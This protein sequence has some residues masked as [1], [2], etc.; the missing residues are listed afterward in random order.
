MRRRLQVGEDIF[1]DRIGGNFASTKYS[2]LLDEMP[3]M[4]SNDFATW[5]SFWLDD[6]GDFNIKA[7]HGMESMFHD[8]KNMT[9]KALLPGKE[10]RP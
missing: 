4:P 9:L 5:E 1:I 6:N 8:E 10:G 7:K 2:F 3:C